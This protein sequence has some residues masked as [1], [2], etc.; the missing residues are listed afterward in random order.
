MTD[1]DVESPGT[2]EALPALDVRFEE[3]LRAVG[4]VD[5]GVFVY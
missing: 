2:V 3:G 1:G 5:E 4:E